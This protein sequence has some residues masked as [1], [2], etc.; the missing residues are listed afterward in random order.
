MKYLDN[1]KL[2]TNTYYIFVNA[3]KPSLFLACI[4]AG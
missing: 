2:L 1:R 4:M 3:N